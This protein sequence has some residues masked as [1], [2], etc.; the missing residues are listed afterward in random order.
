MADPKRRN[1]SQRSEL[2]YDCHH[3]GIMLDSREIFVAPN[4]DDSL[5]EA[6]IDHVVAN[7]FIRNLQILNSMGNDPILVHLITCGG[8][9]NYGIAIYDAIKQSCDDPD[10]SDVVVLA[11]AHARSMSSI[12]PQAA[13]WRIIMPHSD[14]LIHWGITGY[15]GNHTS[16]M[17]EA[18]Q[19]EKISE[20]MLDIYVSR[21]IMGQYWKRER[22]EEKQ[23]RECLR[24]LM[25]KKQEVYFTG[26]QA[27]DM[28]F[29]DAVLGDEDFETVA[30]LR[31]NV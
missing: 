5:D 25:D 23:I 10:L 1:I 22:M 12:I 9:W 18:K 3:F 21:C 19:A 29:M 7:Q 30:R 26:R 20:M 8:D 31:E 28:G 17:Q 16:F 24:D 27:V 6:M 14:F 2:I 11:Y 15:E 13:K 4:L